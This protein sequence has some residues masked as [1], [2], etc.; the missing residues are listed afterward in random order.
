M[1]EIIVAGGPVMVPLILCSVVSVAI[2]VE[3]IWTLQRK[4]VIPREL[5]DRVWKLV[6][7]RTLDD[8]HIVALARNSPLGQILA[9]GLANRPFPTSLPGSVPPFNLERAL[10]WRILVC[11]HTASRPRMKEKLLE[12]GTRAETGMPMT[13]MIPDA[14]LLKRLRRRTAILAAR[15]GY[16]LWRVAARG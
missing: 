8:R 10:R 14:A 4:R 16:R 15:G 11:R 2:V 6:E 7:T 5:T 9:A 1:W 3:R 13:P 12:E